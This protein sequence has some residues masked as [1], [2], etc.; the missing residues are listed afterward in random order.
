MALS[1]FGDPARSDLGQPRRGLDDAGVRATTDLGDLDLASVL[2]AMRL[3]ED[4]RAQA[5]RLADVEL[6]DVTVAAAQEASDAA[7]L[8]AVRRERL[9]ETAREHGAWGD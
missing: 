2:R 6:R 1:R 3:A 8:E 9:A 5:L 4:L 7:V